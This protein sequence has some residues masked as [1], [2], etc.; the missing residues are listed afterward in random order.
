MKLWPQVIENK[1][2]NDLLPDKQSITFWHNRFQ[3]V[4]DGKIDSWAYRWMLACWLHRGLSILPSTSLIANVGTSSD[5]THTVN[6]SFAAQLTANEMPFPLEHPPYIVQDRQADLYVQ[7]TRHS[8]GF[9]Y[10]IERK[11]KKILNL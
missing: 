7:R 2:L 3:A 9:A 6:D 10:R 1:L 11:I 8:A 5:A 4:Y